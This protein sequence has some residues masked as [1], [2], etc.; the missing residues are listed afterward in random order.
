MIRNE[1]RAFLADLLRLWRERGKLADRSM[2][3]DLRSFLPPALEILEKPP[4]PAAGWL[5]RVMVSIIV[6]AAAWSVLGKVDVISVAEGKIIPAGKVR[7]VQP[8]AHGMVAA[9]LVREGEK[10]KAGQVLIELDGAQTRAEE[11]R[12][13]SERKEAEAKRSRRLVLIELLRRPPDE[14]IADGEITGHLVLEGDMKNGLLLLEE[15][16]AIRSQRQ[17][18]ESQVKERRA[19]LAANQV[20]IAKFA[21]NTPLAKKR[22]EALDSLHQ[23]GMV[24]LIDFMSAQAYYNDQV[25]GLKEANS[26]SEQ[27]LAGIDSAERQLS[28]Q[29]AQSLASALDE[30]DTLATRLEAIEQELNKARDLLAKQSLYAPV[31]GTVKGLLVNTIGGVVTPAEVLMEIVPNDETL[32]VEAFLG[33]QDVGYVR[34][35]QAAEIK[36][37]TYPFT[38][39]G[40]I[41]AEVAHVAE[42][43]TVDENM[44]LVYRVRLVL[45]KNAI[46]VDGKEMPLMPGMAVSAE[47]AT[48]KRRIIEFVLAPLLRM[49]DESFRER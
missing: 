24:G 43:A 41:E 9:I 11:A 6:A 30:L 16:R 29:I 26:R 25:F 39:Y 3:D 49:K 22:L 2:S 36:V 21:E 20:A 4:H 45:A 14:L 19:E 17:A 47:I 33:N 23:K 48:D 15:Y 28:A 10:V 37:A 12:L 27:L 35:G 8:Y 38:K 7:A 1:R 32:E 18:L 44:G 40:V 42:D 13:S 34:A 46:M 5:L 31:N